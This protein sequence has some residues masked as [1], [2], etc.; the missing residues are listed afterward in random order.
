MRYLPHTEEDIRE[1]LAQIGIDSLADLFRSIPDDLKL[2]NTLDLP[3]ALS[4]PELIAELRELSEKNLVRGFSSFVGAGIY[5]HLAPSAVDHILRR[6]E[7]YTA[8]TPYQPEVSQGTLQAIFEYQ[9]LISLLLEAE[10]TNASMYDGA[11]GC[12]EAALMA[13]RIQRKRSKV[14]IARN[15]HPEFRRV[16][17]TYMVNTPEDLVEVAFD[18]Q[19]RIDRADLQS[20][21]TD[22]VACL[23]V[24]H[25]NY[26]GVLESLDELSQIVHDAKALLV[27]TFSEP[28]AYGILP[29]PGRAGADII[30]GEGQSFLG[31]MN[32]GG[33][34]LG[35]F[36]T[37]DKFVR[38][39]PG[40][41]C[42]MTKDVEGRRGFVLTLSTREQHIRREKATSN[43]CTNQ[44]L[45][46]LSAA[47]FLS[48]MG[49]GGLRRLAE[50]NLAKSEY[51]KK[52]IDAL[53][54]YK[55]AFAAPSFNEF[56]IHC[57][58][59]NADDV[60]CDLYGKNILAGVDLKDDYPELD[61]HL[62][63]N[64]TEMHRRADIDALIDA[65]DAE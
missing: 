4:E 19:G 59:K 6:S 36:S 44:G 45:C 51:L 62:L 29:G 42:G 38:Q 37:R 20:K 49:K 24:G 13:R 15:V 21:L 61:S 58:R 3:E 60:R 39:M 1:M 9:T 28:L 46:A 10:V 23:I 17:Q 32:F 54:G 43:I 31:A 57:A 65:L 34:S 22:D 35:I 55:V 27:V 11:T 52:R 25:P 64:V 40:R 41:V 8:Y 12:A 18:D 14:L 56:V 26:F 48:L 30:A 2:S 33:P 7:F 16:T 53:E 5:S 50:I 47:I 63:L